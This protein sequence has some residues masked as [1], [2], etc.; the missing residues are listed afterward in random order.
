MK[1]IREAYLE[2]KGKIIIQDLVQVIDQVPPDYL[3]SELDIYHQVHN[4]WTPHQVN[5][6]VYYMKRIM[7]DWPYHLCRKLLDHVV[8]AMGPDSKV[9]TA[10]IVIPKRVQRE[11]LYCY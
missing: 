11:D 5:A 10:D 3:P 2:I 7:H 6:T 4:F 8:D 1:I 9:L